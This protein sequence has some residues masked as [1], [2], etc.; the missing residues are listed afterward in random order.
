MILPVLLTLATALQAPKVPPAYLPA[1]PAPNTVLAKVNGVSIKTGDVEKLLWDWAGPEVTNDLILFQLIRDRAALDKVTVTP[2][3]VQQTYD[4]QIAEI[5]KNVPPGQDLDA[6]IREKGFPMSRLYLHIQADLLITKIVDLKF[7]P[8]DY[9]SISTLVVKTKGQTPADIKE[10]SGRADDIYARL[11]KGEDWD[12]VLA[13][14]D[15]SPETI[16]THGVLGWRAVEAFPALTKMEFKTLKAKDYTHPTTTK[17]GLQIFRI[18]AFGVNADPSSL[19]DL[20]KQYEDR[21]KNSLV[22]ELQ[23]AAKIEKFFPKKD[24]STA[25][26]PVTPAKSAPAKPAPTKPKG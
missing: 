25:T 19:A 26:K 3:E 23:K 5:K 16:Q 4:K 9:I 15:Q 18:D 17:N 6:F 20:K 1:T 7:K 14:T 12:K 2:A 13:S 24:A 22:P 11:K 21:A 8:S 10:A